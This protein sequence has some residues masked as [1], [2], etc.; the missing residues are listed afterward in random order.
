M[1]NRLRELQ[2]IR[3]IESKLAEAN[4][5]IRRRDAE[6]LLDEAGSYAF[7]LVSDAKKRFN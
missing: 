6:D 4:E 3:D 2:R 1:T 5:K 7:K